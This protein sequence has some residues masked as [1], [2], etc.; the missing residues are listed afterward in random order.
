MKVEVLIRLVSLI[1]ADPLLALP[2]SEISHRYYRHTLDQ[3]ERAI[4]ERSRVRRVQAYIAELVELGLAAAVA[5]EAGSASRYHLRRTQLTAYMLNSAVAL[6]VL[7]TRSANPALRHVNAL[8]SG[9]DGLAENALL[10]T[11]E[12]L[13]RDKLRLVPDGI[14]RLPASISTECL[15]LIVEALTKGY[16]VR[17]KYRNS[18]GAESRPLI[19][20][21][22]LVIKDGTIY[23]AAC[24]GFEDVPRHYAMQ[25]IEDAV[26]E[27]SRAYVRTDFDLDTYIADQHQFAHVYR[28][29]QSPVTLELWVLEEALFHFRERPLSQDQVITEQP[30]QGRWF[31]LTATVPYTVM[32]APFLW[33]HAAWVQVK[34]PESVRH[35][36][37]E[38]LRQAVRHYQDPA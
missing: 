22:G 12:K 5:E 3:N 33:S 34:G 35:R 16:Q 7:W 25:R 36:V 11:T 4:K 37:V 28:D 13:L 30:V 26:I 23:V 14:G 20:V 24:T 6:H 32:L 1:P 38:G 19:T 31:G 15:D 29:E 2:I 27:N 10:S 18:K 9:I 8:G 21:L 17:I